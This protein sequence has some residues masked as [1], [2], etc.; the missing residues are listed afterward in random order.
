MK[1]PV[2][3][4]IDDCSFKETNMGLPCLK[5]QEIYNSLGC[6]CHY[7]LVLLLL[8]LDGHLFGLARSLPW[9]IGQQPPPLVSYSN[10]TASFISST[11]QNKQFGKILVSR[12]PPKIHFT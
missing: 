3:D 5:S 2:L 11:K 4:G 1:P 12:G 10:I 9:L 8:K 7:A 6:E